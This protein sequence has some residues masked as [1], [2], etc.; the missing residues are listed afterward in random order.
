MTMMVSNEDQ[1]TM[2]NQWEVILVDE[3]DNEVGRMEKMEAH[4]EGVL[5][6]AFSIFIFNSRGE[7]LIHQRAAGKYHGAGL[8]TNACCSHPMPGERV[9][10]AVH[11][12]LREEMGLRCSSRKIFDF[13]YRAEVEHGLTEHEY[14]HV[15]VGYTDQDPQPDD[16]EVSDWKWIDPVA[17]ISDFKKYP[18]RYTVWF[19]IALPL[20]LDEVAPG[21]DKGGPGR[22]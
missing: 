8:W 19:G 6:R 1:V 4:R 10:D 12:R 9:E 20:V 11:R 13:I 22:T 18:E 7:M 16:E 17:L 15:F 21:P 5:H 14:D 3:K 2:N